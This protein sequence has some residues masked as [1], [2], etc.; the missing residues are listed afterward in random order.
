MLFSIVFKH[1]CLASLKQH[2]ASLIQKQHYAG[3]KVSSA[4][5]F[6]ASQRS[7]KFSVFLDFATKFAISSLALDL[8]TNREESTDD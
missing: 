7:L 8:H 3:K 6:Q 4:V 5:E 2:F 1:I